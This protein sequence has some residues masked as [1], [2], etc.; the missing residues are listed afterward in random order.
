LV[1][2]F[3]NIIKE[4]YEKIPNMTLNDVKDFQTKYIKNKPLVYCILGDTNDLDMEA[5]KKMGTV[6]IL[7]Q[8]EIFGY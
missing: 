8:K 1:Q 4:L 3:S 6:T 5:L 7:T 2:R